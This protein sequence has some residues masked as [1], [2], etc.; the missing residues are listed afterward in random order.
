MLCVS[1]TNTEVE[2]CSIRGCFLSRLLIH[3]KKI[4]FEKIKDI[5]SNPPK[6]ITIVQG[7]PKGDKIDFIVKSSNFF[8]Q[9]NNLSAN[10]T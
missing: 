9:R 4:S 5:K 7:L 8:K 2:M 1:K 10:E 6:D 3:D